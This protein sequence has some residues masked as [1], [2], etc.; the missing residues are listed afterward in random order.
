MGVLGNKIR[1]TS[2]RAQS[3]AFRHGDCRATVHG[4]ELVLPVDHELPRYVNSYPDYSSNVVRVAS[5]VLKKHPGAPLVDV[6][7]NVGDTTCFWRSAIRE[8]ILA[9][10]GD[11]K[12]LPYFEANTKHLADVTL[13][14]HF[15]G[16]ETGARTMRIGRSGGTSSLSDDRGGNEIRL[17]TPAELIDAYPR[18]RKSCL[19][20]CD[21]D[22]FD[23]SII[24]GFLDAG[25]SSKPAFF[26]EHDPSMYADGIGESEQLRRRL[27]AGG[28]RCSLWWDNFGNFITGLD[29]EDVNQWQSMTS[30][31]PAVGGAYYWDVAVFA[32]EDCDIAT[33]LRSSELTRHHASRGWSSAS[34]E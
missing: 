20:K 26:F 33:A 15:L 11:P 12:W 22:G 30:Y 10:E 28:Y 8:P 13:A 1:S 34:S 18:F 6:G 23:Y 7:A 19:V 21:T 2:R 3:A 17:I 24:T 9:V 14:K 5:E 29:L 25:L 31:V 27:L 4:V 16:A 32:I